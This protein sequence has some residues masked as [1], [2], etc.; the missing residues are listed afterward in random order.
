MNYCDCGRH[1]ADELFM[2][3]NVAE[4]CVVSIYI[5]TFAINCNPM[6]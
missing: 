2:F 6:T 1:F 4:K 5:I 3:D